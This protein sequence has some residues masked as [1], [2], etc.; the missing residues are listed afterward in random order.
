MYSL[1][2]FP[3]TSIICR[4]NPDC[5]IFSLKLLKNFFSV[6]ARPYHVLLVSICCSSLNVLQFFHILSIDVKNN[7]FALS[8]ECQQSYMYTCI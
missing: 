6:C 5:S 2:T 1:T 3:D 8:V 4:L 7:G